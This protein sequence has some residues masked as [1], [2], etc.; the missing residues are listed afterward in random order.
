MSVLVFGASA[1]AEAPKSAT[2]N[3]SNHDKKVYTE[4]FDAA[5]AN[6]W[7]RSRELAAT[8]KDQTQAKV[9]KWLSLLWDRSYNDFENYA[10]FIELNPDWPS[11]D[12]LRSKAEDAMDDAVPPARKIEWFQHH[13]PVSGVGRMKFAEALLA[14][15]H[16]DEAALWIKT[17]WIN[18]AFTAS[19]EAT[20]EKKFGKVLTRKDQRERLDTMLWDQYRS[21]S[22]RAIRRVGSDWGALGEARLKLME[23]RA[24]VDAAV[25]R[26]PSDLKN[27]PGLAYERAR[28]RRRA[29]LDDRALDILEDAPA[30]P[31][32][33]G[34]PDKWWNERQLQARRL[35]RLGK[36]A[37]AYKI[38]SNHGLAPRDELTGPPS[39]ERPIKT[40][41]AGDFADA[42][43]LAGWISLT[44]LKDPAD[45][46][47]HFVRMYATVSYPISVA[48]G[49][50]WAGR[51]A[52]AMDE[53]DKAEQWYNIAA[54]N[55][56]T[57]YG[58]L[59]VEKTG[60]ATLFRSIRDPKPTPEQQAAFDQ[61]DL[62][63]IIRAMGAIG[64]GKWLKPF[65]LTLLDRS[66]S[67][68]EQA[69]IAD[70]AQEVGRVDLGVRA[71]KYAARDG[72]VLVDVS[73]PTAR[74]PKRMPI[75]PALVHAL[76]RQE[77]EFNAQ[78][79]SPVGARGLM[80]LMPYT[81]KHVA[82]Q[83]NVRYSRDRLTDDMDYNALLGSSYLQS[84]LQEFDGSYILAVAAYNAGDRNVRNWL[85][86]YGD[87]RVGEVDPVDW[88]ELI[89]F[90]E[91]RNYVQ[92]VLES[93]EVYR[94]RLG[95]T[96][97]MTVRLSADLSRTTATAT[98]SAGAS[99]GKN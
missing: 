41:Y 83:L 40:N 14:L 9:I 51:A 42:E 50:Y 89:P 70:L 75:E 47:A 59:A 22:R 72:L 10:S 33:L 61:R 1:Q 80:Q 65:F 67:T 17:A 46:Y 98:D 48:R 20:I 39:P 43:W 58:Q 27:D 74:F 84:L 3:V 73:Y 90:S 26:V 56:T 15:G 94:F 64:E 55:P 87:P 38:V 71:G 66:V 45:A 28:W 63:K 52:E 49:A 25:D 85:R 69:M 53:S 8:A 97:D 2:Y 44:Y 35:L 29:G 4:A 54:R 30:D 16:T 79:V 12:R 76:S 31:K 21:S 5:D 78:A 99:D 18:D 7:A 60:D 77:S 86:L 37:E 81:A 6:Q 11:M 19:D 82:R 57:F 36:Y 24:G 62:V 91:T 96:P 88:I 92:R 95:K 34:R 13:P 23:R 68:T 93:L 32:S